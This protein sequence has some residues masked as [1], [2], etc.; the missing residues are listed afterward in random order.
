MVME[1]HQHASFSPNKRRH[2]GC[3]LQDHIVSTP[4]VLKGKP[5]LKNTRIPVSRIL[6]YLASGS[7]ADEIVQEFPDL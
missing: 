7:K 6:G 1:R 3:T 2:H 4:S 5:R